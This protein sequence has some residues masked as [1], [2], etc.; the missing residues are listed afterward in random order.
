MVEDG[1][2]TNY[3]VDRDYRKLYADFDLVE[4]DSK[5]IYIE[6]G[7]AFEVKILYNHLSLKCPII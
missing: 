7:L 6:T 1:I 5:L 3:T 4:E 2:L